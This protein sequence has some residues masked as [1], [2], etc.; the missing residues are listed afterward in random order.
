[1]EVPKSRF[2]P[3]SD[4]PSRKLKTRRREATRSRRRHSVELGDSVSCRGGYCEEVRVSGF[5]G[6]TRVWR[7][8]ETAL[9]PC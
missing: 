6:E 1:M 8:L 7:G 9:I 2:R 5:V 3:R 4:A